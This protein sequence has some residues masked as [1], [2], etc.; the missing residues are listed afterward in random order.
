MPTNKGSISV[1]FLFND[2]CPAG[3]KLNGIGYYFYAKIL[4]NS[5]NIK[6][7][8]SILAQL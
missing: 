4:A 7:F 3:L 1:A 5:K 2:A 6:T 8:S